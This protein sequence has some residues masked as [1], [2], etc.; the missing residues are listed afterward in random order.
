[1]VGLYHWKNMTERISVQQQ[2]E[3]SP[4]AAGLTGEYGGDAKKT[5]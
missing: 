5:W 1:M 3:W 4:M 2:G